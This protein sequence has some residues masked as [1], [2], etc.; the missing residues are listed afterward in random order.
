MGVTGSGCWSGDAQCGCGF[1]LAKDT[2]AIINRRLQGMA[3]RL[4]FN[5]NRFVL[6]LP[7]TSVDYCCV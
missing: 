2:E 4:G 7:K 1:K 5:V 3:H 6:L